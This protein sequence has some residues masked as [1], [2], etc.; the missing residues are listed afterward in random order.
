MELKNHGAMEQCFSKCGLQKGRLG[1]TRDMVSNGDSHSHLQ[2]VLK[3]NLHST[4]FPR[5]F[6]GVLKFEKNGNKGL[7]IMMPLIPQLCSLKKLVSS[8]M[9]STKMSSRIKCIL[10]IQN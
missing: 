8:K 1:I 5:R 2:Q 3:P 7:L 6:V 9:F 4:K 10:K